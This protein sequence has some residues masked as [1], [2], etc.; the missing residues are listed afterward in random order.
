[1]RCWGIT[2]RI[3]TGFGI[4]LGLLALLASVSSFATWNLAAVFTEYRGAAQQSLSINEMIENLFKTRMAALKYRI[5]ASDEAEQ[6]VRASV[7]EI[8]DLQVK[9]EELFKSAPAWAAQTQKLANDAYKYADAFDK[10]A[11]LQNRREQLVSVLIATGSKARQQ[12]TS[13][14]ETAYRDDDSNAAYYAGIAQEQLMLGRVYAERYL[15]TNNQ[16]AF[17]RANA[18]FKETTEKLGTL[19]FLLSDAKRI[20]HA[21]MTLED[22]AL[23]AGTLKTLHSVLTQRNAIRN[24]Q[25]DVLG[26]QIQNDYK[27]IIDAIIQ[28]QNVIGPRGSKQTTHMMILVAAIALLSF[29]IGGWLALQISRSVTDSIR[30]M[31]ADMDA[32]AH[33]NFDVVIKGAEHKHELGLMAKALNVFR[34]N[35][36]RIRTLAKEKQQA[37]SIVAR[38]RAE[39]KAR[40]QMMS[41]LQAALAEVVDT[42]VAGDFSARVPARF[43]NQMLNNLAEGVNILLETTEKGLNETVNVLAAMSQGDLTARITS[44]YKGAFDQL[45]QDAN[46]TNEQLAD[47]I[48]KIKSNANLVNTAAREISAGNNDLSRRTEAQALSLEET[49]K[50]MHDMTDSV[51][52]N[53]ENAQNANQ[54]AISAQQQA[55][56]GADIVGRAVS[57]MRE[58]DDS[59]NK[60]TQIIGVINE[61]TFQT[62]LLALNASVEAARAGEHGRGFAVVAKEVR[63]LAGRSATAAKQ[64]EGLIGDSS[65]KVEEGSRL[66]YQSGETLQTIIGSVKKVT[67]IVANIAAASQTQA[68]GIERVT[69]A[70]NDID[71]VTQ[72]NAALVQQAAVS[73]Q[74]MSELSNELNSFVELFKFEDS[75][76]RADY[77]QQQ[78]ADFE[79]QMYADRTW[80]AA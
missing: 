39:E 62:N 74:S 18:H 23:Y 56:Q 75:S 29:A 20:S 53:A 10:M 5:A 78:S 45:K 7:R 25:L 21:K 28:R 44:D 49:S 17:D 15:L 61:I 16:D 4:T 76:Q 66:V 1:M 32:L 27:K 19:M 12:L 41:K 52:R 65:L 51:K 31:A 3:Y 55:Q 24:Q 60:I 80:S 64:I 70:I 36:L 46:K 48:I 26:P 72:Q 57:A 59:S 73:A 50:N 2:R 54:L 30:K 34:D 47:I 22:I 9:V 38:E 63:N 14:M 13:V 8:I 58:I 71:N 69:N 67:E 11:K 33:D 79:E 43:S 35:G 77:L 6:E 68:S 40:T 37:D 42:A